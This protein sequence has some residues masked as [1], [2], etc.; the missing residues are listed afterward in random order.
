MKVDIDNIATIAIEVKHGLFF[1]VDTD[2]SMQALH[3]PLLCKEVLKLIR[4][5]LK[6][7]EESND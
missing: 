3:E 4:K 7:K 5:K 6:R 2:E 1:V